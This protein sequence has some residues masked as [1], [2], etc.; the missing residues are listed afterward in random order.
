MIHILI[1]NKNHF[2]KNRDILNNIYLTKLFRV[3]IPKH[4]NLFNHPDH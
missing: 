2:N 3:M 4:V 1:P